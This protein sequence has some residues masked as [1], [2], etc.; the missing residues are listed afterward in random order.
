M[1]YFLIIVACLNGSCK[2][3]E[4]SQ[5]TTLTACLSASQII[6]AQWAAQH[7]SHKIEAIN[8]ELGKKA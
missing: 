2:D 3:Y 5:M 6:A 4:V 7:P 8:C 1:P